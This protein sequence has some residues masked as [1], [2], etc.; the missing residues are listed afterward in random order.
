MF[1]IKGDG[2]CSTGKAI[3]YMLGLKLVEYCV[4]LSRK[5]KLPP[6]ARGLAA[7]ALRLA[8]SAVSAAVV[9][10]GSRSL[11]SLLRSKVCS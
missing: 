4:S 1:L 3:F 6:G 2:D 11:H 10:A 7:A 8:F 9:R 5:L